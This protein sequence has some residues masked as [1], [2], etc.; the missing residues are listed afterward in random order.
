MSW[1]RVFDNPTRAIDLGQDG[2][3]LI[4]TDD[5]WKD[6]TYGYDVP[7]KVRRSEFDWLDDAE[8]SDHFFKYHGTWHHLSQFERTAGGGAAGAGSPTFEAAGWQGVMS[9]SY[10]TGIL[11]KVSA[12]GEQYKVATYRAVGA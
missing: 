9:T 7:E 4:R 11:I 5:K 6:F 1:Q 12:D 10:S 3:I 8:S 2:K